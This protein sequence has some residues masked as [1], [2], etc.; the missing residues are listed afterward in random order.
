MYLTK[1]SFNT[2]FIQTVYK[3]V[4]E[5]YMGLYGVYVERII[6]GDIRT[7]MYKLIQ[8]KEG[9]SPDAIN[10]PVGITVQIMTTSGRTYTDTLH[11]YYIR[12]PMGG[13]K[14]TDSEVYSRVHR[15][16]T[17]LNMLMSTSYKG[18][19]S[20][21]NGAD[22]GEV[23]NTRTPYL[24]THYNLFIK[25]TWVIHKNRS[26]IIKGNDIEKILTTHIQTY[27]KETVV[28]GDYYEEYSNELLQAGWNRYGE[29]YTYY[30]LLPTGDRVFM[31]PLVGY[32]ST[33]T[34]ENILLYDTQ[35]GDTYMDIYQSYTDL[36][37]LSTVDV[38][39][40]IEERVL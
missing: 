18:Y 11:H 26:R 25:S 22:M 35:L 2:E 23:V 5:S 27:P 15:S 21:L 19:Y 1:D 6:A 31:T 10:V 12:V 37:M 36:H 24:T 32:L 34:K 30:Y 13:T 14:A 9:L 16:L 40:Q 17:E 8:Q 29:R 33:V 28:L 38:I 7:V 4:K 20:L 3:L 39:R